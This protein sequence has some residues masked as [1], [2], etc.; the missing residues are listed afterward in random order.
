MKRNVFLTL[1]TA[2]DTGA[3]AGYNEAET[4]NATTVASTQKDYDTNSP[5]ISTGDAASDV[6]SSGLETKNII[7]LENAKGEMLKTK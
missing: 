3:L 6:Q 5:A 7:A 4:D 1:T 2:S